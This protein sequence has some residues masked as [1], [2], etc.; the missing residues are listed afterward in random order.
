[1]NCPLC[2]TTRIRR[3]FSFDNDF[4]LQRCV[5][6]TYQFVLRRPSIEELRGVYEPP[7]P[8]T[9]GEHRPAELK[10]L[11]L[12]YDKLISEAGAPGKEVLEVGCNTG[13]ILKG[14]SEVGYSVTGTDLSAT[15]VAFAKQRYGLASMYMAEFPPEEK[16][17]HFDVLIASHIIEH[18]LDPKAFVEKCARFV[19]KNGVLIL[20]TPNVGSLGI[21]LFSGHYPVFCPP[22]HLNYFS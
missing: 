8:G 11:G 4:E 21:R 5:N 17:G 1:M 6:C 13:F 22:I 20:R 2:G 14:L 16:A 19:K 3:T 12:L 9:F 18:V 7:P 10:T 15:A